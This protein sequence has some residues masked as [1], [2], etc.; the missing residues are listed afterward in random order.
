MKNPRL[1]EQLFELE[2]HEV[3]GISVGKYEIG[4]Q[5]QNSVFISWGCGT[6]ERIDRKTDYD[7]AQSSTARPTPSSIEG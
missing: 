7:P 6:Q 2:E 3:R 1:D 4:F 5:M